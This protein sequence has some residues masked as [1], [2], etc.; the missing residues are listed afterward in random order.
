MTSYKERLEDI[1]ST[2]PDKKEHKDTTTH[3]W[4]CD[5][6]SFIVENEI[7]SV[8]EIGASRGHTTHVVSS[9]VDAVTS[10]EL[11][12]NRLQENKQLNQ[13]KTNII[14]YQD[15]V[16][17]VDWSKYGYHDLVIIDCIHEFDNVVRDIR[18]ACIFIRPKYI[19]FDDY[20]LFKGVRKAVDAFVEGEVLE[21]QSKIGAPP[22]SN[23]DFT[24]NTSTDKILIDYEGLICK[25]L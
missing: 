25:V 16:Y 13:G 6:V 22:G 1:L 11:S 12:P 3:Q 7:K 10:V 15:D 20:A 19:A 14:Y 8:L 23:F 4:K 9:F 24:S 2:I 21:I 17:Q 5:L 18:N